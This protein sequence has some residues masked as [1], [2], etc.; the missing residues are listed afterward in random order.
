MYGSIKVKNE[1]CHYSESTASYEVNCKWCG[2]TIKYG[3]PEFRGADVD[4]VYCSLSHVKQAF[5][6][7]KGL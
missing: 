7:K 3:K 4:G 1:I 5:K 6:A 2:K